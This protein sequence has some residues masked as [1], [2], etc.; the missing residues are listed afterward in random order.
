MRLL[1]LKGFMKMIVKRIKFI[2]SLTFVGAVGFA[3]AASAAGY[4]TGATITSIGM[5]TSGSVAYIG[6][7]ISKTINPS[8]NVNATWSFAL[9]LNNTLENQMLALLISARATQVPVTLYGTGV[10]DL[11]ST[12]ETLYDITY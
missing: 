8:C 1:N 2:K 9:P 5:N 4:V 12:I 7:N 11:A 6:I 3:T 10:C